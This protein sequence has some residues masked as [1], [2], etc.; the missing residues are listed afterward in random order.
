MSGGFASVIRNPVIAWH[1]ELSPDELPRPEPPP[2]PF[3]VTRS[4]IVTTPAKTVVH[5]WCAAVRAEPA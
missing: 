4:E 1:N 5:I 3:T 2:A